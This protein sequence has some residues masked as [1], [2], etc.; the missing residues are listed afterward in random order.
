MSEASGMQPSGR[1]AFSH[2]HTWALPEVRFLEAE[3]F[4]RAN[5]LL[6]ANSRRSLP[7]SRRDGFRSIGIASDVPVERTVLDLVNDRDADL[8]TYNFG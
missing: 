6:Q 3:Q 2:D 7:V 5:A 1:H 8:F 4:T